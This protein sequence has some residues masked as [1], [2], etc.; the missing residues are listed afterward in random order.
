MS[1]NAL[2]FRPFA[3]P[4]SHPSP[5]SS[6]DSREHTTCDPGYHLTLAFTIA[7]HDLHHIRI[8]VHIHIH[9]HHLYLYLPSAERS[10]QAARGW[11]R[12]AVFS[13]LSRSGQRQSLQ[14]PIA[15]THRPA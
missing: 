7:Q 13:P 8:R 11:R 2:A 5:S 15:G 14:A 10:P 6:W 9:V 4:L 1:H 12:E 3:M